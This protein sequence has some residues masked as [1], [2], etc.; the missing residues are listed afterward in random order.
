MFRVLRVFERREG[1]ESRSQEDMSN[2]SKVGEHL[3]SQCRRFVA[4]SPINEF[5]MWTELR[6]L[7]DGEHLEDVCLVPPLRCWIVSEEGGEEEEEEEEEEME[8]RM[9][10]TDGAEQCDTK[11]LETC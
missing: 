4:A 10:G 1:I 3:S 8:S 11:M 5:S 6:L 2:N 9:E 7:A